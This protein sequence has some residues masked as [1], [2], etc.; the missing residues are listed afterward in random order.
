MRALAGRVPAADDEH[1]PA[2][3]GRRFRGR[4]AVVHPRA[5]VLGH[6]AR[7]ML[8]IEHA[9]GGQ[10]GS[11]D[12]L[13][14]VGERETLVSPI[15]RNLRHFERRE[16][17]RAQP[18]RLRHGA[19]CQFAAADAGRKPEIVLDPRTG[20]RLP[21]RG[22]PVEQQR[23]QPFRCAVHRRRKA[24]RT[25]ADD[26]QVV[27][28]EG[29]RERS[30]EALGHLAGLR[31]AQHGEP[32]SKNSA[33]SSSAPRRPHPAARARPGLARRRASDRE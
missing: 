14:A 26:H 17:L 21:A 33:G 5:G 27:H 16:K 20:A 25:G 32:S 6:A 13:A 4:G 23:P 7:G 31:V 10:H 3:D 8:A 12:N 19:A 24:G 11:R 1:A 9:G 15:D 2:G 28:I 29:G 30:A 22:V 18:L